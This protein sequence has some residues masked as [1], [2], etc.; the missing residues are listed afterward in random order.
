MQKQ[1]LDDEQDNF[2]V[3]FS[4]FKTKEQA[5]AFASWYEGSG[6]QSFDYWGLE[7]SPPFTAYTDSTKG[8]YIQYLN[9]TVEVF[10]KIKEVEE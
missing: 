1:K 3:I 7:Q 5:L 9:G 2:K 4:G 10:L 6:E 8:F